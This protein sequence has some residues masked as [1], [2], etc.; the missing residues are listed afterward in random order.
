MSAVDLSVDVVCY[1][2]V[3]YRRFVEDRL[4]LAYTRADSWIFEHQ[5]VVVHWS[6]D[7]GAGVS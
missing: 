3:N 6:A 5:S 1:R 7:D 4:C 2:S